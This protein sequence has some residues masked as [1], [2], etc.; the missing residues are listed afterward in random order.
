MITKEPLRI[1][2][3]HSRFTATCP[4]SA[5]YRARLDCPSRARREVVVLKFCECQKC[6][7]SMVHF[8][9]F[10]FVG[11]GRGL[12]TALQW[13][14]VGTSWQGFEGGN[15]H[16]MASSKTLFRFRWVKAEHSRYLCALI[17]FAMTSAW[18]YETGSIFFCLKLSRVAGSSLKS[19]FVP[20]RIMGTDGAWW[21][22]SGN[23]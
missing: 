4:D 20:T 15:S 16:R 6:A 11:W 5:R 17:S 7:Y 2:L 10:G 12:R 1:R 13:I 9:F 8:D 19:S 22:I 21:S 23:H 3:V 18:S 14:S